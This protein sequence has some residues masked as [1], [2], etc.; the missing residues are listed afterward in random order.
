MPK[1]RVVDP[2]P[3]KKINYA[4]AAFKQN[5]IEQTW[6]EVNQFYTQCAQAILTTSAQ[7]KELAEQKDLI[8]Y[9]ENINEFTVAVK[10][11]FNDMGVFTDQ[12]AAIY[13]LH[14]DKTG[15]IKDENDFVI[16]QRVY[17]EYVAFFERFQSL[18]FPSI[19]N[20]TDQI[21]AAEGR[22]AKLNKEAEQLN[23]T[24]QAQ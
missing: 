7:V 3:K 2:I 16:S 6:D 17:N 10:G 21:L 13:Q 4:G 9:M 8:P 19:L 1:K 23:Q 11:F 12:L 5:P 18:V 24:E 15:I 14:K 22:R 20:M